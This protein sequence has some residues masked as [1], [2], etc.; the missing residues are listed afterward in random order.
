MATFTATARVQITIEVD[1]G[2]SWGPDCTVE[3][4]LKQ[5]GEESLARITS[6]LRD[7]KIRATV[8]GKP[9]VIAVM[10]G[11]TQEMRDG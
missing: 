1:S 3:Q 11:E 7:C 6:I 10:A 5:A 8:I 2:S 4:V 9:K